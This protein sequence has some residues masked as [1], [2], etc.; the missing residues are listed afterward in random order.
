MKNQEKSA[1]LARFASDA[2]AFARKHGATEAAATTARTRAVD[3]EWRDGKLEKIAESTTRS[4][5][6]ELYV[7][8][9]Y[10]A[11]ATSDLRPSA[12]ERFIEDTILMTRKLAKDE[13]RRLPE[14]SLYAGRSAANLEICDRR[15]EQLTADER[16]HFAAAEESAARAIDKKGVILS[17]SSGISDSK[18]ESFRVTS[19]G[20]E[21]TQESTQFVASTEVSVKDGDGRRPEEYD[22]AATRFF[23]DLPSAE[24]IGRGAAERALARLGSAKAKSAALPMVVDARVAGRLVS[25]LLAPMSASALQQKR[26]FLEGKEG[27]AMGSARLD[28]TDEPLLPRGLASR[29]YDAEGL[30]ARTRPLIEGGVLKTLFVDTYYGR[31]LGRAPTTGSP[32]NITWKLGSESR[33]SILSA[34]K[35]AILVTGFI[36]GNSNPATGDFSLGIRGFF[37]R[38]GAIAEPVGEM[39]IAGHQLDLWKQLAVVGNDPFSFSSLRTPTLVFERVQFAGA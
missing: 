31:K 1:T 25:M 20:F 7:D 4:L 24:A 36:G 27:Q 16:R 3:V 21:G 12:I 26:S 13:H 22:Y 30:S 29:R 2:I 18:T 35:E 19:N 17:V 34:M 39:N 15:Q 6:L 14:P 37:I 8:G 11:V 32:S 33:A 38:D 10:S 9:K 5:Q 23:E 28:L